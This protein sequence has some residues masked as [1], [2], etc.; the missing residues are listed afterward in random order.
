KEV[1]LKENVRNTKEKLEAKKEVRQLEL[2]LRSAKDQLEQNAPLAASLSSN[3]VSARSTFFTTVFKRI[4]KKIIDDQE[5][6]AELLDSS[7]VGDGSVDGD[8]DYEPPKKRRSEVADEIRIP[9]KRGERSGDKRKER[10][11]TGTGKNGR[12]EKAANTCN[13][14]E[15]IG[16]IIRASEVLHEQPLTEE[17]LDGMTREQREHLLITG[18]SGRPLKP[19]LAVLNVNNAMCNLR[20]A[21][22]WYEKK[23]SLEE[24]GEEVVQMEAQKPLSSK[25]TPKTPK[26]PAAAQVVTV[27][28]FSDLSCEALET[29]LINRY[30]SLG[31]T[32][33]I[34]KLR[35]HSVQQNSLFLCS[36]MARTTLSTQEEKIMKRELWAIHK[37]LFVFWGK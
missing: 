15:L 4:L 30:R 37:K 29:E 19:R 13:K 34:G 11:S 1:T 9:R 7:S 26:M 22:K 5:A 6:I 36:C 3:S 33:T 32:V 31:S 14:I 8:D 12:K 20:N 25:Q 28:D 16:K 35:D 23:L 27:Q 18:E 17:E 24:Q 21:L 10:V 2:Q